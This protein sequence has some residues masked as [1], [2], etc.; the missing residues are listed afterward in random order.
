VIT[1]DETSTCGAGNGFDTGRV[2][3]PEWMTDFDTRCGFD[4][5]AFLLMFV[6]L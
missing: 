4:G 5:L 6:L 2:T 3:G 1:F